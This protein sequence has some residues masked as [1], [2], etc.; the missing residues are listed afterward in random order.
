MADF[1]KRAWLEI[2]LDAIR[3]NEQRIRAFVSPGAQIMAVI[4]ADAYG[5]GVE[6]TAREMS[7]AGAEWFAVSNLEEA[8]QVRRAGID[9]PI[10]ILGY[11]PPEYARQ[12]AVNGISQAVFDQSYG[13]RLAACAQRDGVQVRIHVKVDTGMTRIGFPYRDN[14]EDAAAVDEI[15]E[16]CGLP[17]LYPEG[18]FTHFSCADERG[19]AEVYTRLQYD[20]FLNMVE[21]LRRR[22]ISFELRHCCN[23][24][25]TLHYPE[26]HLDLVRPGIILYGMMPAPEMSDPLGLRPA[27]ELKTVISQIKEVPA[28]VPVSYGRAFVTPRQMRLATVPV[29][30]AD[31]YPRALSG[32]AEMLLHGQRVPVV[33]RVCMDQCMLDVTAVPAAQEGD[34]V[35]VFGGEITVDELASRAGRINYEIICGISKRVPRVFLRSGKMESMTDY[36][37]LP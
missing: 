16:I 18:I 17:G 15:E 25:A 33:G 29:G 10:L 4:K 23:S 24:A 12:L 22:G 27:M 1:L 28:G 2:N 35:T 13:R 26:M 36:M 5:H 34:T 11:T 8:I 19:N 21:R 31:G 7:E 37:A 14:V 20:L 9:K 6:Y 3:E 32:N 30:Y